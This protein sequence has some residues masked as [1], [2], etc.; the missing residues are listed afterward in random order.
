MIALVMIMQDEFLNGPSQQA[1]SEQ[2]HPLQAGF[3]DGSDETFAVRI[4]IWGAWRLCSAKI[5]WPLIWSV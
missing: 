5:R 2:N 4:E 1:F 3:L